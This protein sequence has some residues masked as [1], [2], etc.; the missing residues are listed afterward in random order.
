VETLKVDASNVPVNFMGASD[1]AKMEINVTHV[2]KIMHKYQ[3]AA[4][5]LTASHV[6]RI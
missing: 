2:V 1:V 5:E 4:T 6:I 3:T